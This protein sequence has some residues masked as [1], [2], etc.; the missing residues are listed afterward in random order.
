MMY[1]SRDSRAGRYRF[2]FTPLFPSSPAL[3]PPYVLSLSLSLRGTFD[4][5]EELLILPINDPAP[6]ILSSHL[7]R[8][9]FL[10]LDAEP[11]SLTAIFDSS[12]RAIEAKRIERA[13]NPVPATRI[14][15]KFVMMRC[16][17]LGRQTTI[18]EEEAMGAIAPDAEGWARG[19]TRTCRFAKSDFTLEIRGGIVYG[20]FFLSFSS[21]SPRVRRISGSTKWIASDFLTFLEDTIGKVSSGGWLFVLTR[22]SAVDSFAL[23]I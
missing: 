11:R 19:A 6:P 9:A 8:P 10:C 18:Y 3:L 22:G 4:P 16:M 21:S 14:V 15:S 20:F 12:L 13:G 7:P 5:E 2:I 23:T 1:A 17:R